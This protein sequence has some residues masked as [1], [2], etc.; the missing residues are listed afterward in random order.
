MSNSRFWTSRNLLKIFAG[1]SIFQ[2]LTLAMLLSSPS[3]VPKWTLLAMIVGN[4]LLAGLSWWAAIA[5]PLATWLFIAVLTALAARSVV[6]ILSL[7]LRDT[8]PEPFVVA[9]NTAGGIAVFALMILVLRSVRRE[10]V[11]VGGAG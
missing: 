7:V 6:G 10:A 1:L 2:C 11:S 5:K 3:S 8:G 9:W 4:V